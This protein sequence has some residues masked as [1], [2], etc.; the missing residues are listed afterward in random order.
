[1]SLTT[2]TPILTP[3]FSSGVDIRVKPRVLKAEFG[4]GY[5][6]TAGDG[7]NNMPMEGTLTWS[8]L[9]T[10]QADTIVAFFVARQGYEAFYYTLPWEASARK[11]KCLDWQRTPAEYDTYRLQATFK[12]TYVL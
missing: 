2:F 4:D 5:E 11:W 8:T 10:A 6:Q 1:M 9:T 12:E 7:L 3:D